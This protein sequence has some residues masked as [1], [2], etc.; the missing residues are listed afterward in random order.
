MDANLFICCLNILLFF[1]RKNKI[2]LKLYK[3][4]KY[5]FISNIIFTLF[6]HLLIVFFFLNRYKK[7]NINEL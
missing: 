4:E 6:N 2:V 3:I 1:F 5:C 7:I